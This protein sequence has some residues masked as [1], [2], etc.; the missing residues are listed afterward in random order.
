[1]FHRQAARSAS[2]TGHPELVLPGGPAGPAVPTRAC[3]CPARPLVK[4]MMPA[5]RSRRHPVDLW[6]CGHH[7]RASRA[8]LA[9]AG[10]R[11]YWLTAPGNE[12][13]STAGAANRVPPRPAP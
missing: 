1:M 4:V 13:S 6:L 7:Y 10:A 2:R 12:P 11:V 9:A 3:C 5:T 8:A